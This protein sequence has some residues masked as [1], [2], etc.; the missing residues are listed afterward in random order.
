[1]L[2]L[3]G[4]TAA[5]VIAEGGAKVALLERGIF[6]GAKNVSGAGLYDTALLEKIYPNFHKEA[7]IERYLTRKSLGFITDQEIDVHQLSGYI[8]NQQLL[9]A[10]IRL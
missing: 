3:A 4:S 10:V 1:M 5:K 8:I 9:T 7:P 2:V 6:P